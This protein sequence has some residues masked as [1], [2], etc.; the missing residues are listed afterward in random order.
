MPKAYK[1]KN[2]KEIVDLAREMVDGR[3]YTSQH[4]GV[5]NDPS[6]LGMVFMPLLFMDEDSIVWVKANCGMAYEYLDKA[7]PRSINGQPIF[8]SVR[9]LDKADADRVLATAE[10]IK[11]AITSVEPEPSTK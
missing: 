4:Y 10:K 9:F 11:K 1:P 5:V 2:D 7:S 3:I 6:L 8:M